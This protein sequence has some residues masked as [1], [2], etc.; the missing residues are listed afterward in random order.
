MGKNQKMNNENDSLGSR[1]KAYEEVNL[2]Y[3]TR[4]MPLIIRVDGKAFHTL[5]RKYQFE[6]P[7]D[8][9]FM[10]A[11]IETGKGLLNEIQGSKLAYIQ[12][13]EIS[14]LA[15]DYENLETQSWFDKNL[16]KMVSVSASVATMCFNNYIHNL[17]KCDSNALFDSRIFVLP[18]EEVCNYAIWRQ[19]DCTRNSIQ[20]LGQANFSHKEMSGL[21]NDQVQEKLF[22][23]RKIN[24]NDFET[25]K[26]RGVCL[27]KKTVQKT[28]PNIA[29]PVMRTEIEVDW[30]IPIFTQD[31]NYVEKW[32]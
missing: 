30:E 32:L 6:K 2:H 9:N 26:K 4:R 11:M 10:E 24:W 25:W 5:T 3:L 8:L 22:Q 7:F 20:G 19:K 15:T 12:S 1:M 31:R 29:E 23:E 13:D 28:V 14:I 18:K 21:N 17:I 16:Q 27:Y